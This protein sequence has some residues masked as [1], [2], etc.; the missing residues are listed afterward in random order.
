M[1]TLLHHIQPWMQK[2]TAES[3]ARIERRIEGMMDRKVQTVNKRLQAFEQR[4]LERPA[5]TIDLSSFQSE[6]ASLWADVY[7]NLATPTAEPQ[8]ASTALADDMVLDALFSRTA[9]EEPEPTH[10]KCKRH[11][12]SP[13]EEE[14]SQKRRRRQEKEDRKASILDEELCQRRER[15]SVAGESSS[16][17]FVEVPPVVRDIVSTTKGAMMDDVGTT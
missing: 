11:R 14:K 16:A 13:T 10:T 2:S 15:E 8:A 12:S 6:L 5:P 1:A 3:E 4:I 7:A 17:P 9:E